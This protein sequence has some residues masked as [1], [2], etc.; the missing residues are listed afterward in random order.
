MSPLTEN[1]PVPWDQ[2]KTQ[3]P[4]TEVGTVAQA[5]AV[6]EAMLNK[7]T[8]A[9][10]SA[11]KSRANAAIHLCDER[12]WPEAKR[13]FAYAAICCEFRLVQD[14]PRGAHGGDRKSSV[15]G[16][17]DPSPVSPRMRAAFDGATT[18]DVLAA[19]D[20]ADA[21]GEAVTRSHVRTAVESPAAGVERKAKSSAKRAAE[22][23]AEGLKDHQKMLEDFLE[24]ANNR[25]HALNAE[26]GAREPED[27]DA[28]DDQVAEMANANRKLIEAAETRTNQLA[29]VRE[30]WIAAEASSAYWKEY[31]TKIEEALQR[32]DA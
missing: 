5:A 7:T 27:A 23:R 16:K 3:L 26:L 14:N 22:K 32:G 9:D 31:A 15:P 17:L 19:K 29:E 24:D 11:I 6:A 13:E 1:V 20:A 12:N 30:K 18:E 2:P 4:S 8:D 25:A 21:G 10:P 28:Y